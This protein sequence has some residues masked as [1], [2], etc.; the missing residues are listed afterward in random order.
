MNFGPKEKGGGKG[1]SLG[2]LPADIWYVNDVINVNLFY[3]H[4]HFVLMAQ[5]LHKDGIHA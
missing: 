3:K 2:P 5:F 1:G 4:N